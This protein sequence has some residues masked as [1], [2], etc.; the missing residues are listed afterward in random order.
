MFKPNLQYNLSL[1]FIFLCDFLSNSEVTPFSFSVVRD[2]IRNLLTSV[3]LLLAT[4]Y[5]MFNSHFKR[6]LILYLIVYFKKLLRSIIS[7]IIVII[8]IIIL[9]REFLTE[10]TFYFFDL[11]SNET[12]LGSWSEM[13]ALIY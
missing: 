12:I 13:F 10:N 1:S 4:F 3:F 11:S 2:F 8:H 5:F 7:M 6:W 9:N